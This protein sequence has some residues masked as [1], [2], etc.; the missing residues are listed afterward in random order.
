M[1]IEKMKEDLKAT[2]AIVE[3]AEFCQKNITD[4]SEFLKNIENKKISIYRQG[5]QLRIE[6]NTHYSAGQL[7]TVNIPPEVAIAALTD[8]LKIYTK[9]IEELK[10]QW[11][12]LH[13]QIKK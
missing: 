9:D 2:Q 3:K 11:E 5:C 12:E 1:N 10:K 4:I 7:A 13:S 6:Y 8:T